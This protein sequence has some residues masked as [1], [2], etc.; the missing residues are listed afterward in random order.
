MERSI[1]FLLPQK[2]CK[3]ALPIFKYIQ[4]GPPQLAREVLQDGEMDLNELLTRNSR[5]VIISY[6]RSW[7]FEDFGLMKGDIFI[8]HTAITPSPDDVVMAICDGQHALHYGRDKMENSN[9]LGTVTSVIKLKK[10][11]WLTDKFNGLKVSAEEFFSKEF[12]WKRK[13]KDCAFNLNALVRHPNQS[14]LLRVR[15]DS[16]IDAQINGG[17]LVLIDRAL[18]AEKNDIIAAYVDGGYTLKHWEPDMFHPKLVPANNNFSKIK[19]PYN[20]GSRSEGVVIAIIKQKR[21]LL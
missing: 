21:I 8:M 18:R 3:V 4:A 6:V 2:G 15:G 13:A 20:D 12:R 9:S 17:D 16:M 5:H 19:V 7:G 10:A 11:G 14:V 1:L